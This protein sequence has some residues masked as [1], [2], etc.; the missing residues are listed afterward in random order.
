[1][2]QQMNED[3]LESET[4]PIKCW[5]CPAKQFGS[6]QDYERHTQN[7]HNGFRFHCDE[8]PGEVLFKHISDARNHVDDKHDINVRPCPQPQC[9]EQFNEFN[10]ARHLREYHQEVHRFRCD[11]CEEDVQFDD[12]ESYENHI[13]DDHEGFR[14]KCHICHR[15]LKT[16]LKSHIEYIHSSGAQA[17]CKICNKKYSSKYKLMRHMKSHTDPRDPGLSFRCERCDETFESLSKLSYHK[18]KHQTKVFQCD[19]CSKMFYRLKMLIQHQKVH[20]DQQLVCQ[21]CLKSFTNAAALRR[22]AESH[23]DESRWKI[24]E[25]VLKCNVCE[26]TFQNQEQLNEHVISYEGKGKLLCHVCNR[27]FRTKKALSSH[28]KTEGI[29]DHEAKVTT[30]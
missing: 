7:I 12:R 4:E 6:E 1:M 21:T 9:G 10:L 5:I 3:Q 13:Y 2:P 14:V 30:E 8:C 27:S 17:T 25:K 18:A 19:K 28:M 23:V 24:E 22:H 26:K 20:D 11:L 16:K 15:M 29:H